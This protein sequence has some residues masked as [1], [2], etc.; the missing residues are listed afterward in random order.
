[1]WISLI[2]AVAY[3]GLIYC[4]FTS[5]KEWE[6]A[7]RIYCDNCGNTIR[8]PQ[9]FCFGPRYNYYNQNQ[10]AQAQAYNQYVVGQAQAQQNAYGNLGGQVVTAYVPL[11]PNPVPPTTSQVIAVEEVDL[12]QHC[13]SIW[14]ARV[15]N[16]T[17]A[18]DV[19]AKEN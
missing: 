19:P 4:A 14:M 10:H 6:V 17:K 13:V 8:D 16:L 7:T 1:M 5:K 15:K 12:C 18:S 2:L 3:L 9:V 11:P